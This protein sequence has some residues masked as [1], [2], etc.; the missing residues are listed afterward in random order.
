ML[1]CENEDYE[2]SNTS[3]VNLYLKPSTYSSFGLSIQIHL[4]LIFISPGSFC[5]NLESY[6]QIH[7]ML[8]FITDVIEVGVN[9]VYSNTSHVN[10]YRT[11]RGCWGVQFR[12]Q[13]HLMLI[14]IFPGTA[15][16]VRHMIIQIHLMLIFISMR[17]Y[18]RPLS[19]IQIHLMLIFI[20][21]SWSSSES[22]L[23]FKY[24]S[25]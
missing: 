25:C 18:L 13:I 12:I 19:A 24:I 6:I 9:V 22:S 23:S 15:S 4:M 8:I 17:Q 20:F 11:S 5:Q 7:L 3:H 2:H 16:I 1:K 10:L 21:S 14:F